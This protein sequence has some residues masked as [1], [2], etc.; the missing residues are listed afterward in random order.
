MEYIIT[1]MLMFTAA[2]IFGIAFG[3]TVVV[4]TYYTIQR[5]IRMARKKIAAMERV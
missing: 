5:H 4:L 3:I 1:A 2:L